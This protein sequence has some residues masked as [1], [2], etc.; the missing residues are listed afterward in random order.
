MSAEIASLILVAAVLHVAWNVILKGAGDPL[1]TAA[2]AMVA[3]AIV[4]LPIGLAVG[5]NGSARP[6]LEAVPAVVALATV[7]GLVEAIY[8]VLLSAAYR[9]GALSVVYPTARG[10]APLLAAVVGLAILGERLALPGV[11]GIGLLLGG[12]LVLVR[13]W[14]IVAPRRVVGRGADWRRDPVV[15]AVATGVAIATYTSLDR[16]AVRLVDPWLYGALVWPA[17]AVWIVLAERLLRIRASR[18][19]TNTGPVRSAEEGIGRAVAAGVASYVAYGLVLL[20]LSVAPLTAVAPLRESAV[21][22]ASGWGALRMREAASGGEAGVRLAAAVA[23]V[24]GA[25]LLVVE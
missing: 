17:M 5:A 4:S 14:R 23:I 8:L 7:S 2:R 13:P 19:P 3:A 6:T 12:L 24:A 9:R 15:L 1:A 11:I 10:T 25:V 20:A 22:L 21:V 16:V 18:G